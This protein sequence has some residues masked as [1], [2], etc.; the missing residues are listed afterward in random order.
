MQPLRLSVDLALPPLGRQGTACAL[1]AHD[2]ELV[3]LQPGGGVSGGRLNIWSDIMRKDNI[4]C[5]SCAL[6]SG[7]ARCRPMLL[8]SEVGQRALLWP[9]P[10]WQQGVQVL[11][12]SVC[13]DICFRLQPA[14][15][16]GLSA[17]RRACP[18]AGHSSDGARE[19]R[20]PPP[21]CLL[22]PDAQRRQ[23]PHRHQPGPYRPCAPPPC[24]EYPLGDLFTQWGASWHLHWSNDDEVRWLRLGV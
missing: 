9:T 4:A 5:F 15:R 24:G 1:A 14:F 8:W 12:E 19:E 22:Q 13:Q 16:P 18:Q 2:V 10:F 23:G 7:S 20:E 6:P 17:E 21:R 11:A 3:R